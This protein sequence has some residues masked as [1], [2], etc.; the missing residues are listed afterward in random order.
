MRRL[1]YD[2]A[3]QRN[4]GLEKSGSF[5]AGAEKREYDD[6]PYPGSVRIAIMIGGGIASWAVVIGLVRLAF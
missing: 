5:K 1:T 6:R 2:D 3:W 4:L